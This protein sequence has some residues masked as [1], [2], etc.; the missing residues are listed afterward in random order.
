MTT[1]GIKPQIEKVRAIH[2]MRQPTNP[3]GVREF[4]GM[5]GYYR[6][7]INRFTDA[8]RP[9]TK[10]NQKDC[11]FIWSDECQTGFEFLRTCLTKSPILKYPDPHKKYVV[12]TDASD[13]V[14]AAFLTRLHT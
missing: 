2:E 4:L 1:E 8:A 10:L 6:K 3:K 14:A 13:Q 12:L 5:V 7:V 11:K 9:L